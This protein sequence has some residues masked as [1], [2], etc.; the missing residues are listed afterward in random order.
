MKKSSF[1]VFY[2]LVSA[3]CFSYGPIGH[4]AIS[5]IAQQELQPGVNQQLDSL[6]G[7]NGIIYFSTWA[8]EIRDL[9]QY[10]ESRPWH[11]QNLSP[12]KTPEMLTELWNNPESEGKHLFYAVQLMLQRLK[13]NKHDVDA[14]KFLIHFVGDLHQPMHLGRADDLGGNR[15]PYRWFGSD[16][17]IHSLWDSYLIDHHRMSY[18]ELA[19]YLEDT[20]GARKLEL[21]Q[22][23]IPEIIAMSFEIT[24]RIYDYDREDT[25]NYTYFRAFRNDLDTML[26]LGGIQLAKMLNEIYK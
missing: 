8:D 9:P 20:K 15:V 3:V 21:Y 14:L 24:A 11:Y 4:R 7:K 23:S 6:L 19:Q 5:M 12:D 2:L 25:N 16:I 10:A 1:L 17:N 26:Y 13:D 18:T 22:M